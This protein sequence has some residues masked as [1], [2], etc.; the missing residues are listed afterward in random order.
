MNRVV[1]CF[2]TLALL[3]LTVT[4]LGIDDDP[5]L[6]EAGKAVVKGLKPLA[7]GTEETSYFEIKAGPGDAIG[8]V[9]ASVEALRGKGEPVYRYVAETSI[10]FPSKVRVL[11]LVNAKL[12]PDFEPIEIE[13]KRTVVNPDGS[14]KVV[15]QRAASGPKTVKLSTEADGQQT[16]GEAPRP[17]RPFIYA[18]ETLVQRLDHKKH[19]AYI[20][21]EFDIHTGRAGSLVFTA[22]T[23]RDGTPT[24]I[25]RYV[26]GGGSYQFW[27]DDGGTLLR[28]G[29]PSIPALFVRTT[30][31]QAEGLKASMGKVRDTEPGARTSPTESA[32]G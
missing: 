2:G 22:K 16:E 32:P 11:V 3:C 4:A 17:E 1:P 27:F 5:A 29:M 12:R 13:M 28:W 10:T 30:K 25:T 20:L 24:I 26:S 7:P 21:R 6:V 14:E 31:E 8:Y 19:D 23:W 9:I 15:V 18:I